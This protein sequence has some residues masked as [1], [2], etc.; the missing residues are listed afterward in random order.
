MGNETNERDRLLSL[1]ADYC[2]DHGVGDLTLRALG[3]AIGT[4]NRMLLYYFGSKEEL[5]AAAL[6]VATSRFPGIVDALEHLDDREL[7]L[8]DRLDAVWRMLSAT[9]NIVPIRLFF[10]VFGLAA[11]HPGRYSAY[12]ESIGRE[13]VDRVAAA[14]RADG[15]PAAPAR[16]LAREVV[17][18]WRGLQ[19]DLLSSGDRRAIDA[20]H[21]QAAVRIDTAVAA[22]RVR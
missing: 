3:Q 10:E 18:L 5:I 1:V 8:G 16:L 17:A 6:A 12:L 13:W 20:A 14:L 2:L 22:L 15:V 21:A 7:P 9:P 11:H 4:N 19:F